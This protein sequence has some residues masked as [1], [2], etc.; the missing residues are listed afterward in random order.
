VDSP[1]DGPGS[2][3][4]ARGSGGPTVATVDPAYAAQGV[5]LDVRVVGTG[6]DQ[7]SMVQ[8]EVG[9]VPA[10]G[11]ITNSTHYVSSTEL[12]ANLTVATDAE[13]RLYDVAVTTSR[14]RKGIGTEKFEVKTYGW[15]DLDSR[16]NVYLYSTMPDGA[17]RTL[18][19]GDGRGLD[20]AQSAVAGESAY[21][22]E[23]CGVRGKLFNST[24]ASKSGDAVF[25]PAM[26]PDKSSC[27]Q[28]STRAEF[29]VGSPVTQNPFANVRQIWRL[30]PDEVLVQQMGWGNSGWLPCGTRLTTLKYEPAQGSG[31]EVTRLADQGTARV[32]RITSTGNHKASCYK[33]SGNTATLASLHYLP[34]HL[35]IVEVPPPAGGW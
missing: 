4:A 32:W 20:G 6:Y 7:G 29:T 9:G 11:I 31:V 16:I 21:P 17:T 3:A 15:T 19:Y 34:F 1:V 30:G 33:S 14:G 27:G 35:V 18:L 13:V 8:L 28:R 5:T 25:Q 10:A 12:V 23:R 26:D 2:I 22:G 24:S